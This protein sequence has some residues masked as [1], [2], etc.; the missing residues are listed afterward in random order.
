VLHLSRVDLGFQAQ[1]LV[2]DADF[3]SVAGAGDLPITERILRELQRL[4]GVANA[5]VRAS[6][7]LGAQGT[8]P[9]ITLDGMATPLPAGRCPPPPPWR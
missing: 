3:P 7:P 2:R 5:A 1:R 6:V 9:A 4:P 8:S